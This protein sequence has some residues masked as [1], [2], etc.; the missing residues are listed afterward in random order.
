MRGHP[1][2]EQAAVALLCGMDPLRYLAA[3]GVARVAADLVLERAAKLRSE[4]MR[5]LVEA[6]G[7]HVG[8]RV[9]EILARA[10]KG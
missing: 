8:N 7:A 2:I 9:G 6:V 1:V 5:S 4:E 3:D 10:F